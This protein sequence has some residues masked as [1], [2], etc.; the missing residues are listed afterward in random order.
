MASRKCLLVIDVQVG[1]FT[2]PRPL[3]GGTQLIETVR[4][5]LQRA[6]SAGAAIIYVQHSAPGDGPL[7]K[8]SDGWTLHPAV[9]PWPGEPV[10]EK[11]HCDAF[12]AGSLARILAS[13]G[14]EHL[15]VCG[16]VTEGCVDTTVRRAFGLGFNVEVA[17]DG[18]STTDSSVLTAEQ[19]IRH[20]NEVFKGFADVKQAEAIT[21]TA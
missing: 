3:F 2:L 16:L 21:F 7:G 11:T 10:I 1:F 5:L 12:E 14:V 17:S 13:L 18:H 8:G 19:I 9:A 20:H 4:G 6:R 15:V